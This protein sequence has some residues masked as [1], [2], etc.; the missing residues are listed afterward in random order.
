MSTVP[1]QTTN[2]KYTRKN[3]CVST[4]IQ[5]SFYVWTE[6]Y[7]CAELQLDKLIYFTFVSL[8]QRSCRDQK[9]DN[10]S[11]TLLLH[12]ATV[13]EKEWDLMNPLLNYDNYLSNCYYPLSLPI[14]LCISLNIK[15]HRHYAGNIHP[16]LTNNSTSVIHSWKT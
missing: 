13:G 9:L 1:K 11:D 15:I 4:M 3:I 10:Q 7:L 8:I 12:N 2:V 5:L 6:T 14:S 16:S